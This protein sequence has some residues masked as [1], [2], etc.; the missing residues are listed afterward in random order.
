M[1][2][3]IYS[4]LTVPYFSVVVSVQ[5]E[6]THTIH[7]HS[8][9]VNAK[10]DLSQTDTTTITT[11]TT[12]TTTPYIQGNSGINNVTARFQDDRQPSSSIDEKKKRKRDPNKHYITGML[13]LLHSKHTRQLFLLRS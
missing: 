8:D 2:N 11:A 6:K 5:I 3:D 7:G 13:V 9:N 4:P 10:L 12:N 1:V